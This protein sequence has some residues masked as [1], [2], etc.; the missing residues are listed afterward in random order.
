MAGGVKG[1]GRTPATTPLGLAGWLFAELALVLVII[2]MGAE[3]A[4]TSTG[5]SGE[6]S[7]P[8]TG[9]AAPAT[10]EKGLALPVSFMISVPPG[11]QG[12]VEDFTARLNEKVGLNSRAGLVL[13]F[14]I[15]RDGQPL[16][17]SQVSGQLRDLVLAADLPQLRSAVE[18]RPYIGERSDGGPGD[19]KVELFMLT[20]PA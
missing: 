4:G 15:S 5:R 8:P 19:V 18:V 13:L 2:T 9:S 7:V 1:R 10:V 6:L 16:N 12:V 20:G 17:G 3:H 14:G 11:G